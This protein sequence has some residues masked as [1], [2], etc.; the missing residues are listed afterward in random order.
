MSEPTTTQ[1]GSHS[2]IPPIPSEPPLPV[3]P[4]SFEK[5]RPLSGLGVTA[6]I[7][8]WLVVIVDLAADVDAWIG[9]A[10]F[11]DYAERDMAMQVLDSLNRS[12]FVVSIVWNAVYLAAGVVFMVWLWRA[13]INSEVFSRSP[14]AR[15]RFWVV[16]GW[17]V[18]VV[19]LWFPFQV[20]RDVWKASHPDAGPAGNSAPI[21]TAVG[22]W[23]AMFLVTGVV[24]GVLFALSFGDATVDLLAKMATV[25]TVA[26]ALTIVEATLLTLLIAQISRWQETRM[27]EPRS[28]VAY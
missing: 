5:P 18:P 11:R 20:V 4:L 3:A 21:A 12:T 19:S 25:E 1:S 10:R 2:P 13:R 14:H 9:Y 23:W 15:G 27:S 8:I 24:N 26:T 17:I 28:A 16:G 6:M 7:T 22:M